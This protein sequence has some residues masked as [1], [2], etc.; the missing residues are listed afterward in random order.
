MK[1]QAWGQV[2]VTVREKSFLINA[3]SPDGNPIHSGSTKKR[4][5]LHFNTEGVEIQ[6]TSSIGPK[7]DL[8]LWGYFDPEYFQATHLDNGQTQIKLGPVWEATISNTGNQKIELIQNEF[9]GSATIEVWIPEEAEV[10]LPSKLTS[11]R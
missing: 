5:C 6:E 8:K 2:H 3:T 1:N 9:E 4:I 10:L 7:K 11:C